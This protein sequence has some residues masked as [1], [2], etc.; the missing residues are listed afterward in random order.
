MLFY[1]RC[2]VLSTTPL[3]PSH[4]SAMP[5]PPLLSIVYLIWAYYEFNPFVFVGY[6]NNC[7]HKSLARRSHR[8]EAAAASAH[9]FH[10]TEPPPSPTHTKLIPPN[11]YDA[12]TAPPPFST[13]SVH[14]LLLPVGSS[15][16]A[17]RC[18]RCLQQSGFVFVCLKV[19]FALRQPHSP[20]PCSFAPVPLCQCLLQ[21]EAGNIN[22]RPITVGYSSDVF[23]YF[24]P[25]QTKLKFPL[26]SLRQILT[27][28]K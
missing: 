18:L 23:I 25:R 3:C 2:E 9:N 13:T 14:F 24:G 21:V 22:G 7:L 17:A 26:C 11:A 1:D 19:N 28:F 15:L 20:V 16:D 27:A 6:L 12:P 5:C 8:I 10:S 4:N